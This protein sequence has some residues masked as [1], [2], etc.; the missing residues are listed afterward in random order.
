M[1]NAV[2]T[3][4][5]R[6]VV[7]RGLSVVSLILEH[8]LISGS[9]RTSSF[10]QLLLCYCLSSWLP[11]KK[12]CECLN[13]G[14]HVVILRVIFELELL[15][16]LF[17]VQTRSPKGTRGNIDTESWCIFPDFRHVLFELFVVC[18]IQQLNGEKVG[19]NVFVCVY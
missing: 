3:C 16:L 17:P 4:W 13:T 9:F 15:L 12:S 18:Y 5:T 7:Q 1:I 11:A 14:M 19:D 6:A 8:D 10:Q 2:W